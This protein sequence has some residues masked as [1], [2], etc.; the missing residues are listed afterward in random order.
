LIESFH[1]ACTDAG[2]IARAARVKSDVLADKI[3]A[4][5]QDNGYGQYDR[6][7]TAMAPALGD[8]MG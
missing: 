6:L 1:L 3:F 5:V 7:I 4:A 2:V 8:D